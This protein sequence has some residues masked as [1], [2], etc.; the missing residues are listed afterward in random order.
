M[1]NRTHNKT[2]RMFSRTKTGVMTAMTLSLA[3]AAGSAQALTLYTAGPGSLA[4]KLAA[5]YEKQTGVKV[6]VFQATTSKVMARLEAEQAHQT[7]DDLI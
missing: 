4:K 2:T 6:D 7:S 5:G 1:M 3:M